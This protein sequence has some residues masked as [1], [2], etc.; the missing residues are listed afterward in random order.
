M[1]TNQYVAAI[2]REMTA[3]A[4]D[5]LDI[6]EV[7]NLAIPDSVRCLI[8]NLR[9]LDANA[10]SLQWK[11]IGTVYDAYL[12]DVQDYEEREAVFRHMLL[13]VE[14]VGQNPALLLAFVRFDANSRHV[15][16]AARAYLQNC[17]TGT[18]NALSAVHHIHSLL[19]DGGGLV[20][21]RGAVLAGL[22]L[23]GD[24]RLC[25]VARSICDTLTSAE[26]R[27]F[28]DAMRNARD[29]SSIDFCLSWMTILVN[30]NDLRSAE[31]LAG[32]LEVMLAQ[33]PSE[34]LREGYFNFGPYGFASVTSMREV[35][36]AEMASDY[37]QILAPLTA[38]PSS[39]LARLG[40]MF[41]SGS[42]ERA[43][44]LVDEARGQEA[45]TLHW[46]ERKGLADRRVIDIAPH[47]ERRV[48]EAERRRGD[49][50]SRAVRRL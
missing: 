7:F 19:L 13:E 15:C 20:V 9:H 5:L 42:A 43:D 12:V 16:A 50:Q 21:N 33:A 47:L 35:T 38:A 46:H 10:S 6:R 41:R 2:S 8:Y 44:Q 18:D 37:A 34:P 11:T 27:A 29:V 40:E 39:K 48:A 3:R 25:A 30:R 36:L 1:S 28:C 17:R 22:V 32:A 49:R 14:D 45:P 31:E 23:F 24:R 4:D 26:I